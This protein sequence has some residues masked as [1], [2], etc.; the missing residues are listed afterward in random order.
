MTYRT[1]DERLD[2]TAAVEM[3]A[4]SKLRSGRPISTAD[5]IIAIRTALPRCGLSNRALADLVA[6]AAIRTRQNVIFDLLDETKQAS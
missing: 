3:Y 5:A 4:A 2:V 1:Q 6:G